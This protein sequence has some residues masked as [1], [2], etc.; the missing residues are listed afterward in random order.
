MSS[1]LDII[2]NVK[3]IK[4]FLDENTMIKT[5]QEIKNSNLCVHD[6]FSIYSHLHIDLS[7]NT[8]FTSYIFNIIKQKFAFKG[9]IHNVICKIHTYVDN[10]DFHSITNDT[11]YT[12]FSI[13]INLDTTVQFKNNTT[14][15]INITKHKL[16]QERDGSKESDW[17]FDVLSEFQC[18]KNSDL[19]LPENYNKN[20]ILRAAYLEKN[21]I[22][23][24]SGYL[25]IQPKDTPFGIAYEHIYNN[26]IKFPGHFPHKMKPYHKFSNAR[27][28]SILFTC[29]NI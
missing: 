20:P 28:I 8:F 12:I 7:D 3:Q 16:T 9:T 18:N 23:D 4:N 17:D 2:T 13:D 15:I 10:E 21:N 29:K 11:N 6:I 25:F 1:Y 14:S 5:I 24:S 22:L 26:C 19:I 27:R